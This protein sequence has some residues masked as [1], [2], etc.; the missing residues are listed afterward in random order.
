MKNNRN[1]LEC[2]R[3]QKFVVKTQPK[4]REKVEIVAGFSKVKFVPL[5]SLVCVMKNHIEVK[6]VKFTFENSRNCDEQERIVCIEI[7]TKSIASISC[8][9]SL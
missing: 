1:H 8:E 5:R 7:S 9:Q 3:E 2:Q 6:A 4:K